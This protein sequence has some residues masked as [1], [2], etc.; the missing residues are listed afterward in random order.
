M[1]KFLFDNFTASGT[2]L[3]TKVV[4]AKTAEEA[5]QIFSEWKGAKCTFKPVAEGE[6]YCDWCCA[7]KPVVHTCES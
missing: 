6:K 1:P 2:Y 7:Y 5:Q 4:N 3:N